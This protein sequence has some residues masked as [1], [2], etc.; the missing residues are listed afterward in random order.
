MIVR[1]KRIAVLLLFFSVAI[2][3]QQPSA[4]EA[5][6]SSSGIDGVPERPVLSAFGSS[7]YGRTQFK[8]KGPGAETQL[9]VYLPAGEHEDGSLGC[10]LVAPAG[11][12]LLT[13]SSISGEYHDE[14]I[15]YSDAG[16]AVVQYSLDGDLSDNATVAD[17]VESYRQFKAA[18]A[19]MANTRN[20]IAFVKN[21]LPEVDL[22]R[23]YTAGHSSAGTVSLLAAATFDEVKG[24]IA[25]A[26]CSDVVAF[27]AEV[28]AD[29]EFE[30]M[31]SG[32]KE[33]DLKY[34]PTRNVSKIGCP[35]FLFQAADDRVVTPAETKGFRKVLESSNDQV[36][37]VEVGSGGHY[38]SMIKKGIPEA[39][40]WL[41]KID[42]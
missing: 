32:F 30:K 3:C 34:C 18:E 23:I 17:L 25:F 36:T 2:G 21:A 41:K 35:V 37:L 29:P 39:I 9:K 7:V 28:S 1:R 10:V 20:A 26:P 15:P 16:F 42:Q 22:N 6:R 27:H 38:D 8:G 4:T 13:G 14:T 5:P 40:K 33:F 19:G 12:N 31:M 24:A 11:T